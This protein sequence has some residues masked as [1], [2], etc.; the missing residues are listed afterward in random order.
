M[1]NMNND[2]IEFTEYQQ[3]ILA[4]FPANSCNGIVDFTVHPALVWPFPQGCFSV[5]CLGVPSE[6][7]D[8]LKIPGVLHDQPVDA[9]TLAR[10]VRGLDHN[11]H[12]LPCGSWHITENPSKLRGSGHQRLLLRSMLEVASLHRRDAVDI[13]REKGTFT[14]DIKGRRSIAKIINQ[15]DTESIT[16]NKLWNDLANNHAKA[17]YR[18]I[19]TK[20]YNNL[21]IQSIDIY[22][23]ISHITSDGLVHRKNI[24]PTVQLSTLGVAFGLGFK[25]RT[26]SSLKFD[27]KSE[28]EWKALADMTW[29]LHESERRVLIHLIARPYATTKFQSK[30]NNYDLNS[31]ISIFGLTGIEKKHY[32]KEINARLPGALTKIAKN[33]SSFSS[34]SR[35]C[36]S[37]LLDRFTAELPERLQPNIGRLHT[38]GQ[39]LPLGLSNPTPAFVQPDPFYS[40]NYPPPPHPNKTKKELGNPFKKEEGKE[41]KENRTIPIQIEWWRKQ[42]AARQCN[43]VP[44]TEWDALN[45]DM[46]ISYIDDSLGAL[47]RWA[48]RGLI[49][50]PDIWWIC[51]ERRTGRSTVALAAMRQWC[52]SGSHIGKY[53]SFENKGLQI[54]AVSD[55]G[56]VR[57]DWNSPHATFLSLETVPILV[58]DGW[59]QMP[60]EVGMKNAVAEVIDTR[61]DQG[62]PTI[63]VADCWPGDDPARNSMV[64]FGSSIQYIL[65]QAVVVDLSFGDLDSTAG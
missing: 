58:L 29:E 6:M 31:I 16:E 53:C 47:D 46:A 4:T 42:A 59:G 51:G 3:L 64:A 22:Q 13:I 60:T 37:T 1:P 15:H 24:N 61:W 28:A 57:Q 20:S 49:A 55:S 19:A 8:H 52:K 41:G 35:E 12:Y 25:L 45:L 50:H 36:L 2:R 5:A 54:A 30:S 62:R 9:D 18:S 33:F 32:T 11:V 26:E 14:F 56:I 21:A 40:G 27:H 48:T 23:N 7:L 39:T 10:W 34:K 44:G 63:I 17:I 43:R 38:V 65:D